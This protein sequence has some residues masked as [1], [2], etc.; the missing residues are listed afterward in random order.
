MRVGIRVGRQ[1]LEQGRG[2]GLL[3]CLRKARVW[4]LR[5][6]RE[7]EVHQFIYTG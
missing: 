4:K 3:V 6:F 1:E 7:L 5:D 2:T